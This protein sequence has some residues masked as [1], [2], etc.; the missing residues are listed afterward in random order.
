[1]HSGSR[2]VWRKAAGTALTALVFASLFDITIR[3]LHDEAGRAL[4]GAVSGGKRL[5]FHA[6]A[7]CKGATTASGVPVQAGVAAAD[8]EWLP[9]GSVIQLDASAGRYK[10]IYTIM[11][12][13]PQ[14]RGPEL[15]IY[16]WSCNEALTFGRRLVHLAV[17]RHGW[18]PEMP[19]I[20]QIRT[21]HP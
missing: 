11:D 20:A 12:T 10:G 4:D 17:L 14:I 13:G 1:M 16:M 2:S 19:T 15:D 6:T 18:N 5:A 21:L 3:D 9:V 8:P 7:Y